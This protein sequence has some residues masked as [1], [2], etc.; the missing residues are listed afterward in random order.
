MSNSDSRL[1]SPT[2]P[3]PDTP[4]SLPC[5]GCDLLLTEHQAA[6]FVAGLKGRSAPLCPVCYT[7]AEADEVFLLQMLACADSGLTLPPAQKIFK[8]LGLTLPVNVAGAERALRKAQAD[9]GSAP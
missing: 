5:H 8:R 1:N 3:V 7:R 9:R 2:S 4:K 6:G